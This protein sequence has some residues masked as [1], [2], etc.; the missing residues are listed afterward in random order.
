MSEQTTAVTVRDANPMPAMSIEQMM[1]VG[2]IFVQSGMFG[3]N[4]EAQGL[5]LVMT[6]QMQNITPIEFIET[7]HIID[8]KPTIKTESMLGNLLKLGGTYEILARDPNRAGIKAR[9]K[10]AEL[11]VTLSW[12]EAKNEPYPYKGDG[13]LKKNWATPQAR[14]QMLWARVC[15]NAVRAVCPLASHGSYTPEEIMD[16]RDDSDAP[17]A[18]EAASPT[19]IAAAA[20]A[21]GE[22]T[23]AKEPKKKKDAAP[24]IKVLP[25]PP[26]YV[27]T[28]PTTAPAQNVEVPEVLA[29]VNS[30]VVDYAA[31][32]S[33]KNKGKKFDTLS[34][35]A[36]NELLARRGKVDTGNPKTDEFPGM[37]AGHYEVIIAELKTRGVEVAQ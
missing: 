33:G 30:V 8:G 7:Y 29:P 37:C 15:S 28:A 14:A 5:I 11:T 2:T 17:V 34:D 4:N 26:N 35:Q 36:L 31:L 9:F 3:C 23:P 13:K 32:P 22:T 24:D 21:A 6:C 18:R 25:A 16:L 20:V 12:D 1:K 27:E 10:D 19:Q